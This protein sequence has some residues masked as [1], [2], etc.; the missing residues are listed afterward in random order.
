MA[1]LSLSQR[2]GGDGEIKEVSLETA[3]R[4]QGACSGKIT[5]SCDRCGTSAVFGRAP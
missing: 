3:L 2:V 5:V 1:R 4:V